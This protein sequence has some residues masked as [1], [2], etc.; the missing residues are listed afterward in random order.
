[1]CICGTASLQIRWLLPKMRKALFVHMYFPRIKW[2]LSRAL[3]W[4]S[5]ASFKPIFMYSGD[6]FAAKSQCGRGNGFQN[7]E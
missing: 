7:A 4:H 1:M 2:T 5:G 3:L 6:T